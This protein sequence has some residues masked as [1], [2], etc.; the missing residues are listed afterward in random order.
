MIHDR[1]N[2]SNRFQGRNDAKKTT[3]FLPDIPVHIVQ[4]GHSREP[5]F[6]EAQ[7]RLKVT[8]GFFF[9]Q[10]G[11]GKTLNVENVAVAKPLMT[12]LVSSIYFSIKSV[13]FR[14]GLGLHVRL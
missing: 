10:F 4:R 1:V 3:I 13:P 8:E 12:I 11:F 9:D 7:D 5:V 6:F 2:F 14:V